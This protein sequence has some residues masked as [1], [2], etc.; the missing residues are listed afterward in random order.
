[1]LTAAS[2]EC[3][4]TKDED[5]A[6]TGTWVMD[7]VRLAVEVES[8]WKSERKRLDKESI[9]PNAAKRGLT[10]LCLKSMWG[11]FTERNDRA[12]TKVISEPKYLCSFLSTPGI[13]VTNLTFASDEVVWITCK[14]VAEEHVPHLRHTNELTSPQVQR[15]ICIVTST[16]CKRMQSI[17]TQIL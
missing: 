11:K 6:L 17:A 5:R 2:G 15:F 8:F 10:K 7:E 9:K 14:H 16:G 13:E 4:H 3:E 12:Q 1:M